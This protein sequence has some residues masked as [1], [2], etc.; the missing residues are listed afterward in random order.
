MGVPAGVETPL[1]VGLP[2]A[3]VRPLRETAAGTLAAMSQDT[4]EEL[5]DRQA[6]VALG[7]GV[8]T[9][10]ET[11]RWIFDFA[12]DRK[13][14]LVLDADAVTC[15]ARL[16]RQPVFGSDQ[17]VLTPHPGELSR[18]SGLGTDEIAERRLALVPELA[19]RWQAVLLLKGSPTVIGLPDGRLFLNPSGDDALARGGA[20]DV[21]TGLIGGLLA[22]GCSAAEAALLGAMVH[23]LAGEAAA[24]RHGRRGV[25]AREI[26]DAVAPVLALLDAR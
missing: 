15:Y 8:G 21:L 23:G 22:Q 10:P 25:L 4:L 3:I 13:R 14:P 9:D 18:L 24:Q 20:G 12:R 2:E 26:A 6:A 16:G 19:Q 17:V 5:L 11:D 1:R 7:P